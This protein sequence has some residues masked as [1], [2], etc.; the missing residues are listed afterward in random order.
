MPARLDFDLFALPEEHQ[1]LRSVVRALAEKQIER[2][3]SDVDERSRFPEEA[4]QA[5]TA[6]GFHA[7]TFPTPTAVKAPTGWQRAS[8]SRRSLARVRRRR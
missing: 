7:P 4:Y 3:A 2:Y 6:A 5:L 8:S 1:Q